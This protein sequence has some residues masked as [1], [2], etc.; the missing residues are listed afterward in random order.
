MKNLY[1]KISERKQTEE[2]RVWRV[3][4][5]GW[6]ELVQKNCEAPFRSFRTVWKFRKGG[7]IE[8]RVKG[9][10]IQV[11]PTTTCIMQS[12]T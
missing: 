6:R 11:G 3:V 1:R 7:E 4:Y 12:L 2:E 5:D 10:E 9:S 8:G